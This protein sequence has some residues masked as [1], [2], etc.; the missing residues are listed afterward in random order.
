MDASLYHPLFLT[1]VTT[2]CVVVG[3]RYMASPDDTLQL[4]D[5]NPIFPLL[6]SLL[7]VFWLG[8]RPISGLYFG[9]T[10]NYALSY[11]LINP[12][13][14]QMD[15]SQEWV[16]QWLTNGCRL[17]NLDIHAFF[18]IVEAGYVLSVYWAVKRILPTKPLLGW[19]FV[20]SSLMFYSFGING[21]RNGLA[22]HLVLL[23]LSY[24]L[25]NRF[26]IS[27]LLFLIAF[28]IHR[29]TMLPITA[30]VGSILVM[31]DVKYAFYIWLASIPISLVAGGAVTNFFSS[32]GFDDRMSNY[33]NATDDMSMF[34]STGFRWDF[35][36]YSAM[37][38]WMA[39][40]VCIKRQINDSWYNVICTTYLLCNAF[41]VMVIR[42]S[43]SN[44]FA[45][46][47]WF[48]YP[49]VIAYPLANLS[50]WEEQDRKTG[51][52]LLLFC[53]FTVFM[54]TVYW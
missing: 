14:V 30:I 12:D 10:S 16:W 51:L 15:W 37:P 48:I 35:L 18:T 43:Y 13:N 52:I 33:V 22:C 9:D 25:D 19:L 36:L 24:V 6:L 5:E 38:V 45:Y 34:S 11:A 4:E 23:G 3:S 49:L 41:W 42:A 39:W 1:L 2:L 44:R 29:S 50:V 21:I 53:G 7:L 8:N 17:A 28:G 40:Y 31:L 26:V 32:L 46:L 54:N 27:S 47:S 20:C